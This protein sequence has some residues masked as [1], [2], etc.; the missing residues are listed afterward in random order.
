MFDRLGMHS[1]NPISQSTVN[2]Q[3]MAGRDGPQFITRDTERQNRIDLP[4]LRQTYHPT[5]SKLPLCI[6]T[7]RAKT[8]I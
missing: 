7:L 8:N 5:L 6:S 2:V 4:G 1:P 3:A